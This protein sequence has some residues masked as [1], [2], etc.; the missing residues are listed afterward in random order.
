MKS[1]LDMYE[2]PLFPLNVVLFP[3][4]PLPLHIFEERYKAMIADCI[5]DAR[6]FGVVLVEQGA[7]E[8]DPAQPVAVGCTA[9]IAQVQPLD[10]GRMLI[11]TVGRERFRIVRLEQSQ[12]YLV[13]LVE[14]APLDTEDEV[15]EAQGADALEPLVIEYLNKLAQMGNVEVE[16]HQIPGDPEGLIYLA[17]TLIQLPTE[18]KQALL[19]IDR[20][21][22]LTRALRLVYRRELALMRTLPGEDIGIFSLN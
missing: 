1:K 6:P 16:P 14:P 9:E 22:D 13:G 4:M 17:A 5:R 3:G 19:A 8:G 7:A 15:W 18:A 11:M 21:S 20:A 12:P 10:Q 2:L